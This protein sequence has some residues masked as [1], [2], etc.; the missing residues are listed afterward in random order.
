MNA[1]ETSIDQSSTPSNINEVV[2][3]EKTTISVIE[4]QVKIDKKVIETGKVH[5]SKSVYEDVE[6]YTVPFVEEN[7]SVERIPKNEYV[8][9][10]PQGIRYEGDVM[11]IP[12][13]KEVAVVVKRIMVVEEL[14]FTKYKTEKNETHEVTLRKEEVEIHR[15]EANA[16]TNPGIS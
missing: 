9:A 3:A 15:T 14:R 8:D 10:V 5:I 16:S 6:R 4:E 12:V 13:L 1:N 2:G 7:V 11:I